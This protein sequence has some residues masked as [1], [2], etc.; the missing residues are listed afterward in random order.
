MAKTK[1]SGDSGFRDGVV[2]FLLRGFPEAEIYTEIRLGRRS[3]GNHRKAD[4]VMRRQDVVVVLECKYQ[5][6][7]GSADEKIVAT[8]EDIRLL[9]RF[10]IPAALVYGGDGYSDG[11]F[12]RLS[13]DADSVRFSADEPRDLLEFLWMSFKMWDE[14]LP[15]DRRWI[16]D[17]RGKPVRLA[18]KKLPKKKKAAPADG[19]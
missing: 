8:L 19:D 11:A 9:Q 12:G 14:L 10:G 2:E 5:T 18:S 17:E 6:T 4:I 13:G 7:S 15:V 1:K 3:L 16:L